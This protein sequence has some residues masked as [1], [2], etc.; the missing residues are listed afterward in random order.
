MFV[1]VAN[2]VAEAE[3]D[4]CPVLDLVLGVDGAQCWDLCLSAVV[5]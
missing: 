2:E 3:P 4:G 1:Q 5:S